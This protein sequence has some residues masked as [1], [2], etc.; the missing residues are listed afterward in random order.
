[1]Q[2]KRLKQKGVFAVFLRESE[3]GVSSS[4][5]IKERYLEEEPDKP[6]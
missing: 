4:S 5:G 6:Q 3:I 1:M 2:M